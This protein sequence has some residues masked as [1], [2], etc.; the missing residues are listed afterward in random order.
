MSHPEHS[1]ESKFCRVR[2]QVLQSTVNSIPIALISIASCATYAH[3]L[4]QGTYLSADDLTSAGF[5]S[6]GVAV[7]TYNAMSHSPFAIASPDVTLILFLD[8]LLKSIAES[9]VD[10]KTKTATSYAALHLGSAVLGVC[11]CILGQMRTASVL[12]YLPFSVIAGFMAVIGVDVVKGAAKMVWPRNAKSPLPVAA[13]AMIAFSITMLKQIGVPSS[14]STLLTI[15]VGTACFYLYQAVSGLSTAELQ[16]AGWLNAE[17]SNSIAPLDVWRCDWSAIDI[18]LLL[19]DSGAASL[20]LVASINRVLITTALESAAADTPFSI[21]DEMSFTGLATLL[22]GAV[23][24]VAMNPTAVM[25]SAAK[26]GVHGCVQSGRWLAVILGLLEFSV[27]ACNLPVSQVLPPFV[28]AGLLASLGISTTLDWTWTV[29]NRMQWNG[30]SVICGMLLCS[31]FTG[32]INGVLLGGT[33]ALFLTTIRFANL[34]VL[35]YHVS[36]VHFRSEQLYTSEQRSIIKTVG[37][38]TQI[39]GVTGFLFE[40]L[41]VSLTDYLFEVIRSSPD[42]QTL[43]L[44]FFGCQGINDAACSHLLKVVQ[45]CSA[46]NIR[47][48]FCNLSHRDLDLLKGWDIESRGCHIESTLGTALRV[49]EETI[50]TKSDMPLVQA[51]AKTQ[52]G[53]AERD[54]LVEWLGEAAAEELLELA[55]LTTFRKDTTFSRQG[56]LSESIFIAIPHYSEVQYE[57]EQAAAHPIVLLRTTFGAVCPAECLIGARSRGLWRLKADSV[58]L[59][60]GPGQISSL[61]EGDALAPLLAVGLNQQCQVSGQM[62]AHYTL[63]RGGG[64]QGVAF[65]T[66]TGGKGL[67]ARTRSSQGMSASL[68]LKPE[69]TLRSPASL[70]TGSE[71]SQESSSTGEFQR[72]RGFV[73]GIFNPS[74]KDR[75]VSGVLLPFIS[76]VPT[77]MGRRKYEKGRKSEQNL[78]LNYTTV[79]SESIQ[80]IFSRQNSKASGGYSRQNSTLDG[81]FAP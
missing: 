3:L 1:A 11:F 10:A 55:S 66:K 2:R 28:L 18:S 76:P 50:L 25:A 57:L 52:D 77:N 43:V 68:K 22:A 39:V 59:F 67:L 41:A 40:G 37:D 71:S 19:P 48:V 32:L 81:L 72:L 6:C 31:L 16:A 47:L 35:K 26:Q 30:L 45:S 44:D 5:L 60:F 51:G 64:W 74:S 17:Q 36:G 15:F 20:L 12:N 4:S 33:L 69:Q 14:T 56:E 49:A 34:E 27:W 29:R 70:E 78:L 58:G 42:T 65:D 53:S 9:D 73:M 62:S 61:R 38:R 80:P 8:Y 21:N 75:A 13:G 79:N 54:R 63:S 46:Q 24:G 7:W 23:C